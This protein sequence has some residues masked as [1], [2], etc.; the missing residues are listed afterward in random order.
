MCSLATAV[1]QAIAK[2]IVAYYQKY[3]DEQSKKEIKAGNFTAPRP[4]TRHPLAWRPLTGV[5]LHG[6][7]VHGVPSQAHL[8][9]FRPKPPAAALVARCD[10]I[11]PWGRSA[12]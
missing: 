11:A 8:P 4:L 12:T 7:P 9:W 1:R 10:G 6:V 3:V 5:L 2:A